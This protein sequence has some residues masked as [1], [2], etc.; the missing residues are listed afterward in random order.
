[1]RVLV[2][3]L[4][5]CVTI[6]DPPVAQAPPNGIVFEDVLD[7]VKG[8]TPVTVAVLLYVGNGDNVDG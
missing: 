7:K 3:I 8:P 5:C 1:V 2:Y 4:F 6:N